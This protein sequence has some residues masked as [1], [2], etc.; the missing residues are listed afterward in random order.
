MCTFVI[1]NYTESC[2]A[3]AMCLN[4][5]TSGCMCPKPGF[6]ADLQSTSGFVLLRGEFKIKVI[7]F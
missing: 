2:L 1:W 7:A 5:L 3:K 6:L 4:V